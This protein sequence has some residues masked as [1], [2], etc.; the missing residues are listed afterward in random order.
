VVEDGASLT[1]RIGEH[2]YPGHLTHWSDDAFLL[3]FDNP[4]IAP[5]LLTFWFDTGAARA[6]GFAGSKIPN[7]FTMDYGRFERAG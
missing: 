1:V 3:T 7:A 6:R 4:D 2:N 5:G